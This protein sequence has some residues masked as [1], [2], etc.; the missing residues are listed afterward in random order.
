MRW[1]SATWQRYG[2]AVLLVFLVTAISSLLVFY[3]FW[4][5]AANIPV[6]RPIREWITSGFA[7]GLSYTEKVYILSGVML[8][9]SLVTGI[10]FFRDS[11]T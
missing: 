2:D 3:Y 11:D 8:I 9:S 10:A 5:G 6:V 1:M 4:S 7:G